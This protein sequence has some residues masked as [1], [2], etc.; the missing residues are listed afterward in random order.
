MASFTGKVRVVERIR[1]WEPKKED[2]RRHKV[3]SISL[4]AILTAHLVIDE[5]VQ[6]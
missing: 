3:S 1:I 5:C 2:G 4:D 6:G